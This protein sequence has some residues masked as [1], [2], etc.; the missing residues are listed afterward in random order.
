MITRADVEEE[1][2]KYS[3][4]E[5]QYR[6]IQEL[7]QR[8]LPPTPVVNGPLAEF[9]KAEGIGL[10]DVILADLPTYQNWIRYEPD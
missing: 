8:E 6:A 1:L 7:L 5:E 4:Q 2:A 3:T 10:A 9:M